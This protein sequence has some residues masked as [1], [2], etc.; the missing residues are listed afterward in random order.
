M[1]RNREAYALKIV[2][3]S[4]AFA[5]TIAI[6]LFSL[7]EVGYDQFHEN[8]DKVFWIV[9]INT[10]ENYSGNRLSV[11]IPGE[12][13]DSLGA[14]QY[15]DSLVISRMKIMHGVTVVAKVIRLRGGGV[16]IWTKVLRFVSVNVHR[17]SVIH[18]V[19]HDV[20]G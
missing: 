4:I 18:H 6:V 11:K 8:A 17:V 13:F 7:N 10:D 16:F 20:N 14:P 9:Q 19:R 15:R 12:I 1:S 5:T 3:L 2:A